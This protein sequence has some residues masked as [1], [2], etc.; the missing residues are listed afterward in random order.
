MIKL[1]SPNFS[2]IFEPNIE[3]GVFPD[4]D[5]HIRIPQIEEV[6]GKDVT[7][8]HRLYPKQN[9]DL[10]VLLFILDA[11]KKAGAKNIFAVCPY[12]PYARQDKLKLEGEILAAKSLCRILKTS[13]LDKL[14]TFDCHFLNQT[15]LVEHEDLK[16]ENISL[17]QDLVAHAKQLFNGES[18]EIIGPD[19]GSKY[20]VEAHGG[21]ALKKARKEYEGAKIAHRD[22]HEVAG[23][24]DV[25]NKNVLILDDIIS[26]GSTMVK[27]LQKISAGGAKKIACATTHGLFLFDCLDKMK[28]YTDQIFSSDSIPNSLAKVSIEEHLK[29][30]I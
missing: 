6:K 21:K 2:D 11:V 5:S 24:V 16:I 19:D 20:L 1:I 29:K 25:K 28:Q 13:G 9:T 22:V 26:S 8:F 30:L 7:I 3:V 10:I 4:R 17:G 15:G 18:F 12:L 27:C 23:E 14:I